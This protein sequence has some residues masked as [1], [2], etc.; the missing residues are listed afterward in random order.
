[1]K[2]ATT[3]TTQAHTDACST[4]RLA[5]A[6]R[7]M[8]V[9]QAAVAVERVGHQPAQVGAGLG[10]PEEVD[11]GGHAEHDDGERPGRRPPSAT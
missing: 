8:V 11:A 2:A 9:D 4:R 10:R 1:M 7:A 3:G 5:S 6:L